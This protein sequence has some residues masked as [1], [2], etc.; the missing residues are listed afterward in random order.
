MAR[1]DVVTKKGSIE[2]TT[3]SL[4]AAENAHRLLPNGSKI[5][6]YTPNGR[7]NISS[8]LKEEAELEKLESELKKL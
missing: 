8:K 4:A 2:L 7:V 5:M 6:K 1:Y 3:T